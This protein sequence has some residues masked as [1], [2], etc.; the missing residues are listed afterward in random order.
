M[1]AMCSDS[2]LLLKRKQNKKLCLCVSGI[3]A[4]LN[5]W[6]TWEPSKQVRSSGPTR[7]LVNQRMHFY[8]V[9]QMI[10]IHSEI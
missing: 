6:V 10:L 9:P 7:D 3:L 2:L 8:K 4:S 5:P 1:G